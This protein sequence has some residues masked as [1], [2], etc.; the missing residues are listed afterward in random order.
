MIS[1]FGSDRGDD[2]LAYIKRVGSS[3]TPLATRQEKPPPATSSRANPFKLTPHKQT[4]HSRFKLQTSPYFHHAPPK[5]NTNACCCSRSS[6]S[7]SC[8]SSTSVSNGSH[9]LFYAVLNTSLNTSSAEDSPNLST[10][11]NPPST[12]VQCHTASSSSSSNNDSDSLEQSTSPL[13][14]SRRQ[15]PTFD[16]QP[17]VPSKCYLFFNF[18]LSKIWARW[19]HTLVEA[20]RL[21][22]C[23]YFLELVR[24]FKR[25]INCLSRI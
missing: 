25:M 11:T 23:V 15:Q 3:S 8:C 13:N 21:L 10:K 24:S 1:D 12:P 4:S 7:S 19:S 14:C 2:C 17:W 18:R 20:Q 9:S 22:N 16:T 6:T 5:V